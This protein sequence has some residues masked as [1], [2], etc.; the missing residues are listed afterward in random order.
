MAGILRLFFERVD[1]FAITTLDPDGIITS[2]N[3]G[4]EAITGYKAHEVVGKNFALFYPAE[5]C[6]EG[7]PQRV[8]QQAATLGRFEET[9]RR[10][11][12]NG[13]IFFVNVIISAVR[14]GEGRL[15]GFGS[16]SRDVTDRL[17][18]TSRLRDNEARL[19]TLVD[20]V[21]ETL[22][23][24]L[25][26]INRRGT[27][28]LYN[29]A[30]E[31]LFG[32]PA[33]EVVG[34][35]VKMLMPDDVAREH[36]EHLLTYQRT[37]V[38]RIIG[39]PRNVYGRRR[40]GSTIAIQIAVGEAT[41]RGEPIYVGIIRDLTQHNRTEAQLRQAQKMEAVGQLT[42]G[43]AHDFN[44]LLMVILANIDG[45]LEEQLPASAMSKVKQIE[46]STTRGAELTRQLLAFSRRQPLQ[47]HP[48]DLNELVSSLGR[49]LRRTLGADIAIKYRLAPVLER[50]NVDRAQLEAA[51]MNLC[52]NARD[53]MPAGGQLVIETE[54]V[55]IDE[56]YV[57]VTPE[58]RV[59]PHI[60]VAVT[61]TG[62]GIPPE[63][64]DR[65]FEPF[66]TTKDASRGT[67]LG[68]S[69]VYGFIKQSNGHVRVASELGHGTTFR[70]YLP[71][72]VAV[73][74]APETRSAPVGGRERILLVE[75]EQQVRARLVEQLVG[76]GYEVDERPDGEAGLAAFAAADPPYD[77]VLTDI[78]MPGSVSGR[79]LADEAVRL[80][81]GISVVLMSG[82]TE[83]VARH[84]LTHPRMHLLAK[85]F[86]K[87]DLARIVRQALDE[88]KS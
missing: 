32:F 20:T 60:M 29:R 64:L 17:E 25:I 42:G 82:Y 66:F 9:G 59:G 54:A 63:L 73:E 3:A 24:G 16:I 57:R 15:L 18:A 39:V 8:L 34:R 41:H 26:V 28:Q 47:P 70:L 68:L 75:D 86:R 88:R 36:D 2:W 27:V 51:L 81:P 56:A 38:R 49:L 79:A 55:D 23:D 71:Q 62:T 76:L 52:L 44:N 87:R 43:L 1:D 78:V 48:T 12:H 53:A 40:D 46:R 67:G 10:V 69:M 6:A 5:D 72:T 37:G 11:D 85:P 45:L 13:G 7:K 22:I 31:Q 14:D 84:G 4:A 19:Q 80:R 77:L 50:A 30:A 21:L 83:E 74:P 33:D 65:I 61:D 58:A 35:N